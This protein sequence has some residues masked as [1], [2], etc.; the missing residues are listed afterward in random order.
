M[1]KN[2]GEILILVAL[3]EACVNTVVR[4]V[5]QQCRR[6]FYVHECFV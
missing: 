4:F 3:V 2:S 5:G 6:L 1:I